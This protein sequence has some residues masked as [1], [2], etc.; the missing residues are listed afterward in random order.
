MSYQ[1]DN[2]FRELDQKYIVP[3]MLIACCFALWGF[4]NDMTPIMANT[5]SK[6]FLMSTFEGG[7]VTMA[8]HLG[9]LVMAIPA[10]IF[11]RRYTFKAGVLV[12]LGIYATGALL[13]VPSK[14]IGQFSP[15][16]IAYFTMTCGLALLETC[17]NPM[18]YCMGSST[19]HRPSTP[20]VPP[21]VCS[22]PATLCRKASV[23][24]RE[25]YVCGCRRYSLTW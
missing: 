13:F 7:L 17:C 1:K 22:L 11:I 2:L 8:N 25:R 10:A 14:Y 4:S 21:S 16:L 15:F 23:H 9:Y 6:V 24:C 19:W 20:W 18:V 5:F 12:G 3:F